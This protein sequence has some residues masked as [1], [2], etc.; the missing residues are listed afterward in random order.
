MYKKETEIGVGQ[1]SIVSHRYKKVDY[2]PSMFLNEFLVQ[3]KK[4]DPIGKID[5]LIYPLNKFCWYFMISSIIT[6]FMTLIFIQKWWMIASGE[7]P[8]NSWIFQGVKN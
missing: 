7:R 1:A 6:I 2:L 3:S 4:P 5:T 8:S